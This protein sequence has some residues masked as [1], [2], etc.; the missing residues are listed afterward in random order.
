MFYPPAWLKTALE[1]ASG[2]G[3]QPIP[4][5]LFTARRGPPQRTGGKCTRGHD[6][7]GRGNVTASNQGEGYAGAKGLRCDQAAA[8]RHRSQVN[9]TIL[10]VFADERETVKKDTTRAGILLPAC[11]G[12][13]LSLVRSLFGRH[14]CN[15]EMRNVGPFLAEGE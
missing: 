13:S 12:N 3:F 6:G 15:R 4:S 7:V 1:E 14:F 11:P 2:A 8:Q 5:L 9:P 10:R